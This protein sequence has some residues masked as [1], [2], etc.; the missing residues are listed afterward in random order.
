MSFF[1]RPRLFEE[2]L[3]CDGEE[4]GGVGGA[5]FVEDGRA[6][7]PTIALEPFVLGIENA[8]PGHVL[9]ALIQKWSSVD[10]AVFSIQ[11]MGELV[12]D[13]VSSIL[14]IRRPGADVIPGQDDDS[15]GPRFTEV[16]V[17]TF[18]SEAVPTGLMALAT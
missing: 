9:T 17:F 18:E 1:E 13:Q 6:P 15:V 4:L 16:D 10:G 5:V 3:R 8:G 14:E 7:H 11:L 2:A 12:Q